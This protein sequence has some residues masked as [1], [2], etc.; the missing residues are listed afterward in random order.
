MLAQ[1]LR[2][3][4]CVLFVNKVNIRKRFLDYCRENNLD[5]LVKL[6][7]FYEFKRLYDGESS[8]NYLGIFNA[9]YVDKK[10]SRDDIADKF[11]ITLSSIKRRHNAHL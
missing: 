3:L 5:L 4:P 11:Y 8:P 9:L 2:A 10:L 6:Q 7:T 1:P